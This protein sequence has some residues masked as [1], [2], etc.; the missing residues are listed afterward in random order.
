M[1]N[2]PTTL[3]IDIAE[4][5]LESWLAEPVR[6]AAVLRHT[7]G[8]SEP[9]SAHVLG[10]V[11][12]V[13]AHELPWAANRRWACEAIRAWAPLAALLDPQPDGIEHH[14]D[15]LVE[16]EYGHLLAET[17]SVDDTCEMLRIDLERL[18]LEIDV[19]T[20]LA[21]ALEPGVQNAGGWVRDYRAM[22]LTLA[23]Y[24]HRCTVDIPSSLPDA[25][26]HHYA[27]EVARIQRE[28][29][30]QCLAAR[31]IS[32]GVYTTLVATGA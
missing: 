3:A 13:L 20:D 31:S 24:L 32:T 28:V 12:E 7:A 19:A 17:G 22:S 9:V 21:D 26:A 11:R 16:Y 5:A 1:R 30:D 25:M 27:N 2:S 23:D 8:S 6:S 15:M 18:A 10:R 29:R 4:R 14:R